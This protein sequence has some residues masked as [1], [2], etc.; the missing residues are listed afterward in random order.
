LSH[1]IDRFAEAHAQVTKSRVQLSDVATRIDEFDKS[2]LEN[3]EGN[4]KSPI[5]EAEALIT[6]ILHTTGKRVSDHIAY[7]EKWRKQI[8][9]VAV[10]AAQRRIREAVR[11]YDEARGVAAAARRGTLLNREELSAAD[12]PGPALSLSADPTLVAASDD[13]PHELCARRREHVL[14]AIRDS[15]SAYRRYAWGMDELHPVSRSGRNW[16]ANG[17]LLLTAVDAL[18]TLHLAGMH[19]ERDE[20]LDLIVAQAANT[21]TADVDVSQFEATIRLVGALTSA[22]E[23]TGSTEA[24]RVAEAYANRIALAYLP[25]AWGLPSTTVN[26]RRG[27]SSNPSYRGGCTALAEVGSVQL[28]FRSLAL[29]TGN[30]TFDVLVTRAFKHI[31]RQLPPSRLAPL[32]V[33]TTDGTWCGSDASL[34]SL[35]DSYYEYLLKQYLLSNRTEP[36]FFALFRSSV[37]SI[38]GTLLQATGNTSDA[39]RRWYLAQGTVGGAGK[40]ELRHSMEHL[41]C[42]FPGALALGSRELD[43]AKDSAAKRQWLTAAAGLTETCVAM[44]LRQASGLSPEFVEF[45]TGEL[46]FVNGEAYYVQRPE[47]MESLF[48]LWRVTRDPK[49]RAWGWDIFRRWNHSCAVPFPGGLRAFSGVR[50]VNVRKPRSDDVMQSFWLAESLKYALL[51]FSDDA[52]FD[53]DVWVLNTEAHPLHI[54][55]KKRSKTFG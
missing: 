41:A 51:L 34:G 54:D 18:S 55:S 28:E 30:R 8:G 22:F 3:G 45:P 43:P 7:V 44:Y 10:V 11:H 23:T 40:V 19:A 36:G 29:H 1:V 49:Y 20:A 4:G 32:Y 47:T 27:N 52:A 46:D 9:K 17:S 24:L 15:W 53:L 26:L 21:T 31:R 13:T 35:G 5:D 48:Y 25:S 16:H 2:S 33:N 42:F 6:L 50:H 14:S 38:L 12:V 39:Q 37:E